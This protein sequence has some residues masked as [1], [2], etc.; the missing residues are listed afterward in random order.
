MKKSDTAHCQRT[1]LAPEVKVVSFLVEQG[2]QTSR[3]NLTTN[4]FVLAPNSGEKF[5]EGNDNS[6]VG[7]SGYTQQEWGWNPNSNNE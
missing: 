1:Y 4:S 7:I 5:F 6:G 2:Y 3:L